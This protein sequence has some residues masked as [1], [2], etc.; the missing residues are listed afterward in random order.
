MMGERPEQ[1]LAKLPL[2][3]L[4]GLVVF[5]DMILHFDVGRVKSINA[6]EKAMVEDQYIFVVAQKEAQVDEPKEEDLFVVGTVCRI[7]QL[8]KL[9]GDTIRV[10][11]EGL[12]RARIQ[13]IVSTDPYFEAE[14]ENYDE[15][16]EENLSIEDEALVRVAVD[17]FE[18]Y[19]AV[20]NKISGETALSI[21]EINQPGKLAD[22]IVSNIN[23]KLSQKQQIL[24]L[25]DPSERLQFLVHILKKE[26]E[27]ITVEK[28]INKRVRSQIDKTQKE[29]YLREQLKVI[30]EELGDKDGIKGEVEEYESRLKKSGMPKEVKLKVEKEIQRLIK[31][32]SGYAEGSVV[33]AYI[34]W[35]LDLPWKS[36]TKDI[37]DIIQAQKVLDEDHFGL[38]KVKDRIIEYLA[39]RQ[40]NPKIKGPILC[41][42][43]PPGVGKTSIAK[44]IARSL[45][46]KYVRLSLGGVRDEAEIRGHRRTY[47]GAMP[48]R[49]IHAMKQ[50]AT[51]NPLILMDEIDKMSSDFRGDPSAALLEV[52]DPEQNK[53]FRDHYLEIEYDLSQVFFL[54][55]ANNLDTIPG[56][57]RD[58]ME[59]ISLPSYTEEEKLQ[60]ALRYLLPK[61]L[62]NHGMTSSQL[63]VGE[64]TMREVIS[65]YTKEAG[66]RTLE[67][68]IAQVC[69]KAATLILKE[70][71]KAVTIN[72]TNLYKFLGKKKYHY[73]KKGE[74]SEIGVV[75]GLAWTPVGGDT[76]SVEVN[77]MPGKGKIQLTGKL[78]D[79]MKESAQAALSYI[80][81]KA[82]ELQINENFYEETDIHIH[83]PEG[84]V[85]KDGPSAGIT[86]AT[87]V[88]SA[89]SGKP[90]FNTVAMTGE[91]TIRG[92]VLAIGGVKEK[93]LAAYRAGIETIILPI[94][95][96][97]DVDD[98]PKNVRNKIKFIFARTMDD[99]LPY[100]L[101]Q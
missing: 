39:I 40:M 94:D 80:R 32:P 8:L 89:L 7:K 11:V 29:Y 36:T 60:I 38:E 1:I 10:L 99:V 69:R 21:I 12:Y 70:N 54:C 41:L 77:V 16:T 55:T 90:V 57:L 35:M 101:I 45:N 44:S 43:G 76:L 9:P 65:Y 79:V 15:P 37:Y 97:K 75:R 28:S 46:R 67:R 95:N 23:L 63:K 68:T 52:L 3:A 50:A 84:A 17:A 98:I 86:M 18:E 81:S 71:K 82:K 74:A 93:V 22:T 73:E 78:G 48:G 83:V 31:M 62:L 100:A 66:V 72:T 61:Q 51:K 33:R 34:E 53:G 30:Q 4:R 13:K 20:T 5:P 2:L 49:I 19:I 6:L 59:I 88:I 42:V 56:P 64:N 14:I 96:E 92:R 85:P 26:I 58:R 87:A 27:V 24:E 47:V 91:I 25:Y